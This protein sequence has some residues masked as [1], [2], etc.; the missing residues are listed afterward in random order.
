MIKKVGVIANPSKKK[1]LLY[2]KKVVNILKKKHIKVITDEELPREQ[3][4]KQ[5]D[6]IIALGGDGTLLN[7]AKYITKKIDILG[8]NLGGFGFLTEVKTSE[9]KKAIE[10][11]LKNKH[12]ISLRQIIKAGII[13][14]KKN[15]H[16]FAALNDIVINKGSLSRILT[17][18]LIIDEEKVA[19][20]LCDG[21]IIATSTGSTAHSLSAQGPILHPQVDGFII[22]PICPHTLS[23]RPLVLPTKS[24]I[25]I[26][27]VS[28]EARDIAVVAD[29]QGGVSLKKGD[30]VR[31]RK[32]K[33][34]FRL[35]T[36]S[37]RSYFAILNEKL[38]WGRA[39]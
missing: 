31:I 28:Q 32:A 24:E 16:N 34:P 37:K 30:I 12:S 5:A 25:K 6:L 29:G 13:R 9:I 1:A 2:Q 19:T 20:Y 23:N 11:F 26:K 35:V 17:L 4:I 10:E 27:V 8:I 38:K 14:N 7:I 36:S 22:T 15:I 21:L 3:V 33:R 39:R 18:E